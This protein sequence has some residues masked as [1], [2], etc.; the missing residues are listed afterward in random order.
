MNNEYGLYRSE[1]KEGERKK[2]ESLMKR[3]F[4]FKLQTSIEDSVQMS[5]HKK[6]AVTISIIELR[7]ENHFNIETYIIALVMKT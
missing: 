6:T 1:L 5:E 2:S 4:R 7:R 3:G